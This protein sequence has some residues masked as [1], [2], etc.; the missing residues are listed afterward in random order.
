MNW[1]LVKNS[2]WGEREKELFGN[3]QGWLICKGHKLI[4]IASVHP[5]I[6]NDAKDT[7]ANARLMCAAPELLSA[8]RYAHD[9]LKTCY[10]EYQHSEQAVKIEE[11][12]E[13]ATRTQ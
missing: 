13:K 7:E 6:E 1:T 9:A 5:N 11:A 12:I 4:P 3:N 2:S 10:P 8:L